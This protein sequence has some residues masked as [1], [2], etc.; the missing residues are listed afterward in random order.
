MLMNIAKEVAVAAAYEAGRYIKERFGSII[1]IDEKDEHG[2]LVTEVDLE[3]EAIILAKLRSV[4]PD[5]AIR[6]EEAGDDGKQCEWQ[7][8]VD[9]LDGTNN[10]AVGLPLFGISIT[11]MRRREPVLSV[12]YEPITDRLYTA[13]VG[14]G[15]NCNQRPV[16]LNPAR[17]FVKAR[18]GWIQGHAVQQRDE[19][20]Q[21]RHYIDVHTKRMM[22]LW[23]PTL[24]WSMLARGDLDAIMVYHSEGEDLYSGILL[25]MEA[26]AVVVDFE[27]NPFS[28]SADQP[29]LIA[30]HP[31]HMSTFM[32]MV[33]E[34]MKR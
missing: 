13:I 27:G 24:Q 8:L 4:F 25:A 5:H 33:A 26:G 11:L 30:C 21:L 32:S 2:D 6:S 9:P 34:G 14:E 28:G 20:V 15:A 29:C 16:S 12:I 17:A 18:V 7:W 19:A 31:E 23:A 3:A 1:R 10:F 22:R